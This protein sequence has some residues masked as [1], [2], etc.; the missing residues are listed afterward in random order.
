[1]HRLLNPSKRIALSILTVCLAHSSTAQTG[2]EDFEDN[3]LSPFNVEAIS[4]NTSEI[5]TPTGFDARGG[6]KVHHI[7]WNEA[8]YNGNRSARGVEGSSGFNLP[9]IT[10]EGWY[11][12]SIYAPESF[13]TPGKAIVLGQMIAWHSSLPSTSITITVHLEP[14]GA[15]I[16]E[17]AYGTGT[18]SKTVTVYSEIAPTLTKGEWH[19][20]ILYCKLSRNETGILRAWYDG[21]PESNPTVEYTGINLGNGGWNSDEEMTHGA[22]VKWG[23]YCWDHTN[24]DTNESREIYYDEIAYIVGNPSNAF[25]TVKPN[26]YGIGYSTPKLGDAVFTE[27]YDS[28]TTGLLPTNWSRVKASSTALSVRESP[29]ASDKSMRFWDGNPYGEIEA[30]R[31]TPL[32]TAPFNA[33]WSFKQAGG[34]SILG[35]GQHMG[36]FSGNSL[37]IDLLTINGNLVYRDAN[38]NDKML[39]AVPVN[40]WYDIDLVVNPQ[41]GLLDIYV[42]GIRRLSSEPFQFA[43]NSFGGLS[44]GTSDESA[45]YH[46]YINDIIISNLAPILEENFDAMPTSSWPETWT[47]KTDSSTN[48]AV[49]E[50]PS[51][52]DKCIQLWDGNTNGYPRMWKSFVP[53]SNPITASWRF[54]ENGIVDG[55]IMQVLS[56]ET[57]AALL[58]TDGLGNLLYRQSNGSDV[59]L[60][61]IPANNWHLVEVTLNPTTNSTSIYVNG[62]LCIEDVAL[63][64]SVDFV[65]RIYF[66]SSDT[67]ASYHLYVNDVLIDSAEILNP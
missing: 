65:D 31:S 38:G 9:K 7:V 53:Q 25:D 17:G 61:S 40:N 55:H 6:T 46:L 23:L 5:I 41:D 49:R 33:H 10:G 48:V 52:T 16:L 66:S 43:A 58:S 19:D 22:Y 18:G 36:L 45:T 63:T 56:G 44:F 1:M 64:N 13:P 11:G 62:T 50:I 3:S 47:Y 59:I 12:F 60:S 15:L 26:N 20:I 4:G 35:E 29:S 14:T 21:A 28:M 30:W 54:R 39:Q 37:P 8:N 27:T 57:P 67:P 34:S 51:A 24:Y 42:D 2:A 32:L